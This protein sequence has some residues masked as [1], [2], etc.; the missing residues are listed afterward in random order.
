MF[1]SLLDIFRSK[2]EDLETTYSDAA[3]DFRSLRSETIQKAHEEYDALRSE[4]G[5][6]LGRL[7]DELSEMRR[8]DYD[9]DVITDV[10]DNI[11]TRRRS[12]IHDV[13]VSEDARPEDLRRD[14][15][16]FI[17]GFRDMS[18][19]EAAVIQEIEI[20]EGF[21]GSLEEIEEEYERLGQLVE[22][23]Y[24]AVETHRRL[25]DAVGRRDEIIDEID[26]LSDEIDGLGLEDHEEE[27]QKTRESLED[28]EES[29]VWDEY[30][31]LK[32]E[33]SDA[34][35]A[36]DDV[37]DRL[38]GSMAETQRGLR[39][40]LYEVENSDLSLDSDVDTRVLRRLRDSEAEDLIES[41]PATVENTVRQM[42]RDLEDG[43]GSD[44]LSDTDR[45]KLLAGLSSLEDFSETVEEVES[46]DEKADSLSDEIDSHEASEKKRSLEEEID[47]LEREAERKR[48]RRDTLR[49]RIESKRE[50]LHETEEKIRNILES[51]LDRDVVLEDRDIDREGED[52]QDA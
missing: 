3:E 50:R 29:D 48:E 42:R 7:D 4:V 46:L 31:S 12:L 10:M 11:L 35:S 25:A 41:D 43:L 20:P 30:S 19:K 38:S 14:L 21:Y 34:E 2:D 22:S 39:K 26:S 44:V 1:D 8:R 47:R 18:R 23:E 40:I 6:T 33:L 5:T 27:L 24:S 51:A 17:D 32:E 9:E 36:R 16:E 52:G 49:E 13:D 37:L 15:A 28:L 45:E